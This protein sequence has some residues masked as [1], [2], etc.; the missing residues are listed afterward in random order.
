MGDGW[1]TSSQ[2]SDDYSSYVSFLTFCGDFSISKLVSCCSFSDC[3]RLTSP[4][5]EES[6]LD[7]KIQELKRK[8]EAIAQ[9]EKTISSKLDSISLLESEIASLQV[10]GSGSSSLGFYYVF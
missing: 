10:C 3:Q 2:M 4:Y 6:H 5:A 9:K 8:D 1:K 7:E